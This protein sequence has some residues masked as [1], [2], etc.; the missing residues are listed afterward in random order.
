MKYRLSIDFFKFVP[1]NT[2]GLLTVITF[3]I[4][5]VLSFLHHKSHFWEKIPNV[6]SGTRRLPFKTAET[7][8]LQGSPPTDTR[9]GHELGLW[10]TRG[11]APQVSHEIHDTRKIHVVEIHRHP[12]YFD[13][14]HLF[15]DIQVIL[16][17]FLTKSL[18]SMTHSITNGIK[19]LINIRAWPF[20]LWTVFGLKQNKP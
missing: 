17:R 18:H 3:V 7:E 2:S 20:I 13:H 4:I 19:W 10:L 11:G 1:R 6:S 12:T 9:R 16:E 14:N 15:S 5:F 8:I